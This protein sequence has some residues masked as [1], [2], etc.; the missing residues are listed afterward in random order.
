MGSNGVK[1]VA[2]A[3][4]GADVT[5]I[6]ISASSARFASEVALEAGVEINYVVS[7]VLSIADEAPDLGEFDVALAELG[8]VHYFTELAPFMNVIVR[9]LKNGGTFVLRDFHPVSTKLLT[10]RGSTAKVRK[11]K[12][13]GD[14]FSEELE[15]TPVSFAKHI[16]GSTDL[17]HVLLRKWTIGEIVTAVASSG[18]CVT[19]LVEESNPTVFDAG[20]PKTFT[21][22]AD[23]ILHPNEQ[24]M[25]KASSNRSPIP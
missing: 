18:L 24:S 8:I 16:S 14:Y 12:V 4:L 5:V 25:R 23:L 20:I 15:E 2:L 10:Y 19:R 9:L 1:A 13:D 6:D 11:Y 17:P 3:V 22:T 7:D 21:L